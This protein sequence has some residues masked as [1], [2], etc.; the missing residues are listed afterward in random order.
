M[1]T[2]I[3]K[4][5]L[6]ISAETANGI[7]AMLSDPDYSEDYGQAIVSPDSDYCVIGT[8]VNG[9]LILEVKKV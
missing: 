3:K 6:E 7:S 4:V 2:R 5:R 1:M 9:V 8:V